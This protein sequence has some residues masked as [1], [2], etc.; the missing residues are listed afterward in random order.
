MDFSFDHT[1][2]PIA[3]SDLPV[4]QLVVHSVIREHDTEHLAAASSWVTR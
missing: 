4:G 1:A 2:I 3:D